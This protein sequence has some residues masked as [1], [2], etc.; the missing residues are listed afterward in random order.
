MT[1]NVIT[2]VDPEAYEFTPERVATLE[3]YEKRL[4]HYNNLEMLVQSNR[5]VNEHMVSAKDIYH[6]FMAV[7][8]FRNFHGI[9]R[10]EMTAFKS[11]NAVKC[12]S[13]A[14]AIEALSRAFGR[15][16]EQAA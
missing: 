4:R 2:T 8:T 11:R 10:R 15:T 13:V 1:N 6:A 3:Q 9:T 14:Q 12:S 5:N 16:S 7:D